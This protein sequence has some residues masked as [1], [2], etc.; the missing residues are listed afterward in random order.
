M[1]REIRVAALDREKQ[2]LKVSY[3]YCSRSGR[4]LQFNVLPFDGEAVRG[5]VLNPLLLHIVYYNVMKS[6]E[7]RRS[8]LHG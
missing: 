2:I 5:L 8:D 4:T 1:S 6:F 3:W 7:N